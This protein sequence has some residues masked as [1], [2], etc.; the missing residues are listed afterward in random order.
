MQQVPG[1]AAPD[2]GG[3][4]SA[5]M[6]DPYYQTRMALVRRINSDREAEGIG[7]VE[8]DPLASHVEDAHCQ[9]MAANSYLSHWNLRGELPYH[10]YHFAGGHDHIQENLS[11]TSIHSLRQYPIP[12]G[13]EEL[14]PYLLQSQERIIAERPP[15]DGHRINVL[16][17]DHTHVGIGL[18]VVDQEFAMGQMFLNR[19]VKLEAFP[20]ML[21]RGSIDVEGEVLRE[22]TGPY[23]CSV[24]YEGPLRRRLAVELDQTYAYEDMAGEQ[25]GT[26]PPWEMTFRERT[27]QFRFN[28]AVDRKGPGLY[29][30]VLWVRTPL[31]FIP[32]R[33][34]GPG[35]YRVDT[36]QAIPAAGWVFRVD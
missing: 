25:V 32:Y 17:R 8:Y 2:G 16:N 31:R 20:E 1:S 3:P 22:D 19:Y 28:M 35:V 23:Y 7:P 29:H 24:F 4:N 11:R 21:T 15:L 5:E 34:G 18:A 27:G 6:D 36:A 30:L 13:P 26:K 12:T 14:T 9:E 10:R 33:L